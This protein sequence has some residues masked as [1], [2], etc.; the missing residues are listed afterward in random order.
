[1]ETLFWLGLVGCHRSLSPLY[2]GSRST[3]AGPA[4]SFCLSQHLALADLVLIEVTHAK[5]N[6]GHWFDQILLT[7]LTVLTEV[8]LPPL[9]LLSGFA[10][11]H[12]MLFTNA[13]LMCISQFL[14]KIGPLS[15]TE[16]SPDKRRLSF[17]AGK[18]EFS[19]GEMGTAD[20]IS[21]S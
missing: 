19:S 11:S 15:Q 7:L 4:D 3:A 5:Y 1:M 9:S 17:L 18:P 8:D 6:A 10:F 16:E 2:P 14:I 20:F 12:S 13:M 21:S